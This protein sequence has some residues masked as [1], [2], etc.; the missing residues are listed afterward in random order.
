MV[1]VLDYLN[2]EKAIEILREIHKNL[3]KNGFLITA[4]IRKNREAIFVTKAVK[5]PMIYKEPK[6]LIDML[7][8]A[9]FKKDKTKIILEPLKTHMVAICQK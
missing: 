3:S 6:D 9:G 5:W 1:G 4:N 2:R 7:F 8:N